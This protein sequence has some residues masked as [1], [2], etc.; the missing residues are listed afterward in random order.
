MGVNILSTGYNLHGGK[1]GGRIPELSLECFVPDDSE[2]L[3]SFPIAPF[4][5]QKNVNFIFKILIV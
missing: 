3:I 5:Y 1:D 4:C 2:S